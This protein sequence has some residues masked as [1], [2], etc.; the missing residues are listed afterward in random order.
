VSE[1]YFQKYVSIHSLPGA[2]SRW[3]VIV[4]TLYSGY[5]WIKPHF[6]LFLTLSK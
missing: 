6:G 2:A 5:S 3:V 4:L 1:N